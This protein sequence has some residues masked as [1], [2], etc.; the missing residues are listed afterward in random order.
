[1]SIHPDLTA[2]AD[3]VRTWPE[4]GEGLSNHAFVGGYEIDPSGSNVCQTCG[5]PFAQHREAVEL[6]PS[7]I[8]SL[9]GRNLR[10]S[11][12]PDGQIYRDRRGRVAVRNITTN[13]LSYISERRLLKAKQKQ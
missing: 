8:V 1:M 4:M 10:V 6:W 7:E 3:T 13:R 2:F 11:V 9:S 5:R 12:S